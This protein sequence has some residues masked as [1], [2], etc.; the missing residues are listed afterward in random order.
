MSEDKRTTADR[1]DVRYVAHLARLDLTEAE[2]QEF[3]AQLEQI[4][5]YVN[6]IR[7]IPVE[8]V[9]PTAHAVAVQNVFREDEVR[10]GLDQEQALANAPEQAAGQFKVPIIVE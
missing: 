7:E 1:I 6:Q 2:R 5:A 3:Q 10:P 9:E 8:G 4:V